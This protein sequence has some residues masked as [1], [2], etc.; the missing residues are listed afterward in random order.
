MSRYRK[1]SR[2][3][4][5]GD[6]PEGQ[7]IPELLVQNTGKPVAADKLDLPKVEDLKPVEPVGEVPNYH[8]KIAELLQKKYRV[9]MDKVDKRI[10]DI[11]S[12]LDQFV[13]EMDPNV[14]VTVVRGSQLNRQLFNSIMKALS[15]DT[16]IVF[17][18]MDVV[19][20]YF[21]LYQDECFSPRHA[22]RFMAQTR[23]SPQESDIFQRLIYIFRELANPYTRSDKA[24]LLDLSTI[25]GG[26]P[27]AYTIHKAN[28]TLYVNRLR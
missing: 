2:T 5:A 8:V 10:A 1:I 12:S 9:P 20:H 18:A 15:I 6:I 11:I 17:M 13:K 4:V 24:K 7:V 28:F 21:Y 27:A 14:S 22:S 3:S 16:S 19:L 23:L 26:F 25:T